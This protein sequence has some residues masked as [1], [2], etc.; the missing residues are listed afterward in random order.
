MAEP[1]K[2]IYLT[3]AFV[4]RLAENLSSEH[5][6][7]DRERFLR[8]TDGIEQPVDRSLPEG[9][10]APDES[11]SYEDLALKARMRRLSIALRATLPDD[12]RAAIA[13]LDIVAPDF[14]GLESMVFPDFV[15]CFGLDDWETSLPALERFTRMGSSEFAVRP[16]IVQDLERALRWMLGLTGSDDDTIRRLASEGSRPRL[17]WAMALPALKA[18]PSPLLPILEALKNDPS[19]MVRRSVANNINDIVKDDPEWALDLCER[20]QG[21]SA[22]TDRLIRH[23][24]RTLLKAGHPRAMRLFGFGDPECLMIE[25]LRIAPSMVRIGSEMVFTFLLNVN[26]DAPIRARID[27]AIDYVKASGRTSRKVFVLREGLLKPG[28]Q[29]VRRV[30]SFANLSTRTHYPGIHR[31]TIVANGVEKIAADFELKPA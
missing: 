28:R 1:L 4:K 27:Y 23:A 7:F 5:S 29:S 20:W 18:D 25:D 31:L 10:S 9:L 2:N 17:P 14:D 30:R 6:D 24:C 12:Y 15:E 8:I 19:E 22:E 21:G 3:R 13:V 16:F 11:T 26:S